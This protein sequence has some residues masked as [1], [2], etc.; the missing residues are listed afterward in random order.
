MQAEECSHSGLASNHPC[1]TCRV[2]GT[3]AFK[4]S[5]IGFDAV[6]HVSDF[7]LLLSVLIAL[8][9]MVSLQEGE[10]RTVEETERIVNSQNKLATKAGA[11]TKIDDIMRSSGVKDSISMPIIDA[12]VRMGIELRKKRNADGTKISNADILLALEN[13]LANHLKPD[14]RNPL[15]GMLGM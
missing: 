6:F 5:D 10:A 7:P 1:R 9:D 13:E 8:I 14:S 4:Q 2:G 12:V 11:A 15:I 3:Q